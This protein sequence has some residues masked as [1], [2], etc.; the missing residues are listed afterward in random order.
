MLPYIKSGWSSPAA[1]LK[2]AGEEVEAEPEPESEPS[3]EIGI[4]RRSRTT[5]VQSV[6]GK[7]EPVRGYDMLGQ[8]PSLEALPARVPS[9]SRDISATI[10]ADRAAVSSPCPAGWA[11]GQRQLS[12]YLAKASTT[13]SSPAASIQSTEGSTFVA[14][15]SGSTRGS[16]L[17]GLSELTDF[18]ASQSNTRPSTG[19]SRFDVESEPGVPPRRPTWH[20]YTEAM[21]SSG[22]IERAAIGGRDGAVW[23]ASNT[24]KSDF[25]VQSVEL[26][27]IAKGLFEPAVLKRRGMSIAGRIFDVIGAD[28]R[29]IVGKS[30]E[31]GVVVASSRTA[32]VIGVHNKHMSHTECKQRVLQVAAHL[33]AFSL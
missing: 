23:A 19:S 20:Q 21:L 5:T 11:S 30:G 29:H 8:S 26:V 15:D 22:N 12:P 6:L 2:D 3:G 1:R 7:S 9:P 28:A 18:S 17:T 24:G 31:R 14:R 13:P 33:A 10:L 4:P 25:R 16:M 27:A 32:V